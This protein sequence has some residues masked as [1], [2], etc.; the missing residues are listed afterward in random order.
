MSYATLSQ[1]IYTRLLPLVPG[2]IKTLTQYE[3]QTPQGFPYICV[4]ED[5][6]ADDEQPFDTVSNLAVYKFK[7]RIV[8]SSQD[9]GNTNAHMR[10]LCDTVL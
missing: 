1:V 2:S 5:D 7:V 8:D 10:A 9:L 3:L 6:T 4:I